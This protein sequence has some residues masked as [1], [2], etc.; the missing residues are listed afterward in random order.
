MTAL[1]AVLLPTFSAAGT[2]LWQ[3]CRDLGAE[4]EPAGG[5]WA[6]VAGVVV[7]GVVAVSLA[8]SFLAARS[9]P[10]PRP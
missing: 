4:L 2:D 1:T 3:R 6:L 5:L 7:Y 9:T 8:I 10:E